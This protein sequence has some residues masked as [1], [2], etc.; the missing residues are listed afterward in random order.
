M[1]KAPAWEQS[2]SIMTRLG[3]FTKAHGPEMSHENA[4]LFIESLKLAKS[5]TAKRTRSPLSLMT[6]A[7]APAQTFYSGLLWSAAENHTRLARPMTRREPHLVC[8]AMCS[9]RGPA[10][11]R[12]EWVTASRCDEIARCGRKN[13]SGT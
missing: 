13:L 9:E 10:A 4:P 11:M 3:E 7:E 2:V 6:A 8:N 12:L 1:R 5:S